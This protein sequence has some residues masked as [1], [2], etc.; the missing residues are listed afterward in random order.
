MTPMR[1]VARA[2]ALAAWGC[3]A[4]MALHAQE[5]RDPTTPPPEAK[6]TAQPG[7]AAAPAPG[8]AVVVQDG[9]PHLVVG[10]RLVAVGHKVGNAKLE[11][12]TETEVWLRE[13]KQLTKVPRFSGIQRSVAKPAVPCVA[14]STKARTRSKPVVT[15]AAPCE[16]VQP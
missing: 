9:K 16:G 15:P 5:Y 13:G 4:A 10:T 6:A 3:L 11:R 2:L 12:I 1:R 8:M 14:P 7:A